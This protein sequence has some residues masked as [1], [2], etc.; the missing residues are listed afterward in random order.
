MSLRAG[1]LRLDCWSWCSWCKQTECSSVLLWLNRTWLCAEKRNLFRDSKARGAGGRVGCCRLGVITSVTTFH[2]AGG[3]GV[4]QQGQNDA[5]CWHGGSWGRWSNLRVYVEQQMNMRAF[6]KHQ[7]PS[8][9]RCL[10]RWMPEDVFEDCLCASESFAVCQFMCAGGREIKLELCITLVA[11]G[12][13]GF[14]QSSGLEQN[15]KMYQEDMSSQVIC[16]AHTVGFRLYHGHIYI[17][18]VSS[19][20]RM[21]L[22]WGFVEHTEKS[23]A[24]WETGL[25]V[26][27]VAVL[28]QFRKTWKGEITLHFTRSMYSLIGWS[29]TQLSIQLLVMGVAAAALYISDK[30]SCNCTWQMFLIW[31]AQHVYH[32]ENAKCL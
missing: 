30:Q 10:R 28:C 26:Q 19:L 8:S 13:Q 25:L 29:L 23:T 2:F 18:C 7:Q 32:F 14:G 22:C 5:W 27:S 3:G 6:P 15:D 4:M 16:T 20:L 12:V 21:V 17:Y 24:V 1:S 9:C 11:D 31:S